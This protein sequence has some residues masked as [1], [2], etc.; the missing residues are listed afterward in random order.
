MRNTSYVRV[1]VAAFASACCISRGAAQDYAGGES[2]APASQTASQAT[3][4]PTSQPS[5]VPSLADREDALIPGPKYTKPRYDDD[6]SYLDGGPGTYKPDFFD[7]MKRLKFDDWTLNIGGEIRGRVESEARKQFGAEAETQDTFFLHRYLL[8]ADLRYRQS[9]RVYLE[10]VT[11]FVEDRDGPIVRSGEDRFDFSQLF[12]DLRFLGE[13]VPLTLRV[14][15]HEMNYGRGRLIAGG[16]W[17]NTTRVFDGVKIFWVGENWDLDVW[18]TQPVTR[19][20][21]SA[22]MGENDQDFYGVYGSYKGLTN[23]RIDAYVLAFTDNGDVTNANLRVGDIGDLAVYTAGSRFGGRLPLGADVWDY[24]TEFAGQWG[25][26]SADTIQAF[27]WSLDTGY[28]F[29]RAAMKPRLGVGLDYA[30]GDRNPFDDIHQT[31]SPLFGNN[32]SYFGWIDQF[33]RKN[34][35]A[36]NTSLKL[37]PIKNVEATAVWHMFWLDKNEDA[38]YGFTGSPS[39]RTPNGGGTGMELGNELDILLSWR[40]DAHTQLLLGYSHLFTGEYL[41]RT[42]RSEDT[43]L[44]YLQYRIQF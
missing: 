29:E 14:G 11:A 44:I 18:W 34:I 1:A 2:V 4:Q 20:P 43:D 32:H 7:P 8:S 23:H 36:A 40:I 42:G 16:D 19:T 24:D 13:D 41:E 17:S 37:R 25:K 3:T 27:M 15:R 9:F 22:D 6:F 35:W 5:S 30:S 12:A 38:Y 39:R 31:F 28:T 26:F 10:G 21:R 33:T